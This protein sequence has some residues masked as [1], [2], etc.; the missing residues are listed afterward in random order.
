MLGMEVEEVGS[1]IGAQETFPFAAT[2]RIFIEFAVVLVC[3]FAAPR[4]GRQELL[5]R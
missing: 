3:C 4:V 2:L 5:P 1:Q